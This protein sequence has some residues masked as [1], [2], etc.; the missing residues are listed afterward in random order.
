MVRRRLFC[1]LTPVSIAGDVTLVTTQKYSCLTS[2]L[3]AWYLPFFHAMVL[4][5]LPRRVNRRAFPV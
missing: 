1:S 5:Y 2:D 4:L 3:L